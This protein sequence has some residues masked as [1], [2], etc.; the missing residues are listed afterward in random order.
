[1]KSVGLVLEPAKA[2]NFPLVMAPSAYQMFARAHVCGYGKQDDAALIKT[3][4]GVDLLK[5]KES[6]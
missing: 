4:P 2:S 5:R 6:D 3:F 1:M